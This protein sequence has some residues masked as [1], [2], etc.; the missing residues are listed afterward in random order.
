MAN[1]AWQGSTDSGRR[2]ERADRA[3]GDSDGRH[4]RRAREGEWFPNLIAI[5]EV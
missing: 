2:K 1:M 3:N 5:T 4:V